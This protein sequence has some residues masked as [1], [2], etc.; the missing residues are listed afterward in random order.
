MKKTLLAALLLVGFL[1][2][3]TSALAG[4]QYDWNWS[5]N[6]MFGNPQSVQ[7]PGLYAPDVDRVVMMS[8]GGGGPILRPLNGG[9]K[10]QGGQLV[11][12][13][14]PLTSITGLSTALDGKAALSHTHATNEINN[15]TQFVDNR[16]AST[17]AT[18]TPMGVQRVRV[19][20]DASGSYTW[21]FPAPFATST[22]PVVSVT[23]EDA[24]AS[25]STDVRITSVSNTS[26]TVQASRI[27]T[28][29]GLLSL[30]STPQIYVHLTAVKP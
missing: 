6:D 7:T 22:I 27:T 19:Q 4:Y 26:V 3:A 18:G 1:T 5:I 16:I 14:I 15:L 28:V 21:N 29:L 8:P 11:V 20:T 17:S 12:D 13:D 30:N 24:T 10:V 9:V 25:A 2:S 23:P